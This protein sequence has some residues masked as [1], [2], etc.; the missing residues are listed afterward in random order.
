MKYL[1]FIISFFYAIASNAQQPFAISINVEQ[2]LPSPYVFDVLE[3]N[4][5][6]IWVASND[7][8]SKYDGF[9]FINYKT[10]TS[11]LLSG[12]NI[13]QDKFGKIWY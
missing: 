7:G 9:E 3:D 6:Y 12:S 8:L 1:V 2:N 10:K 5:G 13:C 11:A 4:S